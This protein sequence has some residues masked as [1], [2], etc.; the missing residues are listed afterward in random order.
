MAN[1]K[2]LPFEG[3]MIYIDKKNRSIYYR[4]RSKMGYVIP[5]EKQSTFRTL[6]LRYMIGIVTIVFVHSVI[7]DNMFIAGAA[8]ILAT[9]LLELRF[10]KLIQS[11]AQIPN[12]DLSKATPSIKVPA[13]KESKNILILRGILFVAFA[14]LMIVNLL[15]SKELSENILMVI[16]SIAIS[17]AACYQAFITFRKLSVK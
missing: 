6:S 9:A 17:L 10:Q 1:K 3:K 16:A 11:C 4:K 12:F 14:V 13:A 8:G 15:I 5:Y 2:E 7:I